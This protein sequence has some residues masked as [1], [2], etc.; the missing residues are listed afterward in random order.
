MKDTGIRKKSVFLSINVA[1][2]IETGVSYRRNR[3]CFLIRPF[4]AFD[5]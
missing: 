2:S 5:Q 1:F 4:T 3:G